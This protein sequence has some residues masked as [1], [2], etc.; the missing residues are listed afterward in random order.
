MPKTF[1]K[2]SRHGTVETNP[3]RDCEVAGSIRG[4]AHFTP[5]MCLPKTH[6]SNLIMRKISE[7]SNRGISYKILAQNFQGHQKHRQEKS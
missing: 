6:N 1:S 7:N 4:L 3:T 2:S 5:V